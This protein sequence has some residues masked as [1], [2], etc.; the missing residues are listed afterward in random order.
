MCLKTY[1][2]LAAEGV[3]GCGT[4]LP[5]E[6]VSAGL[7][8]ALGGVFRLKA[9]SFW[10]TDERRVDEQESL[11]PRRRLWCTVQ[12]LGKEGRVELVPN[13]ETHCALDESTSATTQKAFPIPSCSVGSFEYIYL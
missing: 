1:D 2:Y 8:G 6:M 7:V 3:T 9:T 11:L 13:A 5:L 4:L 12:N 10:S